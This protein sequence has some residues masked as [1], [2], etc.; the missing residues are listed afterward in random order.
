MKKIF[1][2]VL[3]FSLSVQAELVDR[4]AA[5]VN[6]DIIALSEVEARAAP[7]LQKIATEPDPSRRA[8]ARKEALKR[9]LDGLIG[10]KLMES[11]LRELNIDVPDA[12]VDLAIDDVKKQNNIDGAQF[13]QLLGTEGYTMATYR[14][15]M[16]KHLARLKLVNLKVR[17]KVKV[18]DEDLKAEYLRAAKM[19][20]EDSEVHARHLLVSVSPKATPDQVEAARKKAVDLMQEAKR[21]GVDFATLAKKKSEGPSAADGGDL[22]FFRRGVM[23]PEFERAAFTLPLGGVSEPIR[24]KFGWHV[25]KVEERRALQA[26]SFEETKDQLR[27]RLLRGQ[28]EKY[29]D[30]YIQELRAQAVVEEKL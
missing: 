3:L 2:A 18:S 15:F 5:V 25:I 10:E 1:F 4:V 22:G 7:D 9:A 8:T 19:E 26:K 21:P 24:T 29:T 28:L 6:R 17:S 20:T 30:Q 27:E 16:K 11:Q 14:A 13:E 12:E 23:V